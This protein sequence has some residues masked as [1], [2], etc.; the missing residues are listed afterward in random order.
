MTECCTVHIRMQSIG[1]SLE[2]IKHTY[3]CYYSTQIRILLPTQ[4]S[5]VH[6]IFNI[7]T[8]TSGKVIGITCG[9]CSPII[10]LATGLFLIRN[11]KFLRTRF[12]RSDSKLG[13]MRCTY[14]QFLRHQ[15]SRIDLFLNSVTGYHFSLQYTQN[16]LNSSRVFLLNRTKWKFYTITLTD[17]HSLQ[18]IL[19]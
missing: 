3:E 14:Y 11:K 12:T 17:I 16:C 18:N 19:Q 13:C 5:Y 1:G 7:V 10:I 6:R 2:G 8:S 15:L 4:G 9:V